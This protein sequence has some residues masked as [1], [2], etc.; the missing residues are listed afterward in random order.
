[1]QMLPPDLKIDAIR[2]DVDIDVGIFKYVLIKVSGK[3][4]TDG[5]DQS[6]LI[7]RGYLRA[8]WHSNTISNK[9]SFQ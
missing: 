6:K 5:S 4:N 3:K 7:V 8:D 2:P 1:M 9:F